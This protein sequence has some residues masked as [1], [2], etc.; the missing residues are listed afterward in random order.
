[1]KEFNT[2][3]ICYPQKHYMVD[4]SNRLSDI[5]RRVDKGEYIT[6]N[7]G[8]QYGKTT[9]LFHLAKKL[10]EKYVVFSI[11]FEDY[12]QKD[13]NS[14]ESI[15]FTLLETLQTAIDDLPELNVDQSVKDLIANTLTV[16]QEKR[17]I[18]KRFCKTFNRYLPKFFKTYRPDN[19]RSGQCKQLRI[20]YR[21]AKD[22]AKQVS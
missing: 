21:I 2:T 14:I 22:V 12:N 4:I 8:R 11:S 9:T 13:F 10:M 19:R 5:E 15:A 7:R 6:I 20:V 18:K 1:M 16:N 17:E 3:G